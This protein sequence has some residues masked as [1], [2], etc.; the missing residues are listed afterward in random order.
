MSISKESTQK[1][2]NNDPS[3]VIAE[4]VASDWPPS[5]SPPASVSLSDESEDAL[6]SAMRSLLDYDD[7]D[8]VF[9]FAESVVTGASS[10]TISVCERDVDSSRYCT[11]NEISL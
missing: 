3:E 9:D 2:I 7:T 11:A 4:K 1:R 5:P 6:L 8:S 10:P